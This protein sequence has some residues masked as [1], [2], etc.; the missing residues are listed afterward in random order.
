[1]L[2]PWRVIFFRWV[3]EK[4]PSSFHLPLFVQATPD[5][6]T[7]GDGVL[8]FV[9]LGEGPSLGDEQRCAPCLCSRDHLND[10]FLGG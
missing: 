4:P 8:L 6:K 9:D 10:K 3:G 7:R 2:F 1:M 5:L